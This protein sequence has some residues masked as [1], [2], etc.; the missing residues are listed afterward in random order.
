MKAGKAVSQSE[1]KERLLKMQNWTRTY[2][3][4]LILFLEIWG[5]E[6]SVVAISDGELNGHA[7]MR[8]FTVNHWK[9]LPI[10]FSFSNDDPSTL[11][12]CLCLLLFTTLVNH[13]S[14]VP[15]WFF[16]QLSA[17]SLLNCTTDG[18]QNIQHL[19]AEKWYQLHVSLCPN[20]WQME[21]NNI[22]YE[23]IATA[24]HTKELRKY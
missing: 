16:L 9:S 24:V 20:L 15:L 18:K 19:L 4:L 17:Q 6:V 3:L 8:T 10:S 7:W 1:A 12:R 13:C 2:E 22:F 23:E 14:A 21:Y 11:F 5:I